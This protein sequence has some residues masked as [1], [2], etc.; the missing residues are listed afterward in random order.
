MCLT[1]THKTSFNTVIMGVFFIHTQE[2]VT[3]P[4]QYLIIA[5]HIKVPPTS[6]V[7]EQ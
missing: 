4:Q 2:M 1:C 7:N 3:N 6:L 5:M